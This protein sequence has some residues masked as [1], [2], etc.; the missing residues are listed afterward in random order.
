MDPQ[1]LGTHMSTQEE[2]API[3]DRPI[4]GKESKPVK[5]S[6]DQG[7]V[8]GG[9]N[10]SSLEEP[11][12]EYIEKEATGDRTNSHRY[13]SLR[14]GGSSHGE[15]QSLLILQVRD[16]DPQAL[17]NSYI[18]ERPIAGIDGVDGM[19]LEGGGNPLSSC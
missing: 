7:V 13:Q 2:E 10:T 6:S 18:E 15:V 1:S 8:A 17:L 9:V 19:E 5:G 4:L 11:C 3:S 12:G 16:E 14:T